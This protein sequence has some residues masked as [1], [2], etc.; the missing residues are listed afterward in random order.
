MPKSNP[1]AVAALMLAAASAAVPAVAQTAENTA[2]Q[3]IAPS[4]AQSAALAKAAQD[5][6]ATLT[7]EQRA[8]TVFAFD[9]PE[10]RSR[11]T[12]FPDGAVLQRL[13]TRWGDLDETQQSALM[14][15]LGALL[16]ERG[17]AMVQNQMDADDVVASQSSG[18]S[19]SGRPPVNFGGDFYYVSFVGEPSADAP[20]M[21]Q[22]GGHHLAIN[23]TVVGPDITLSPMLTGGE[24][25]H[26]TRNGEN[27]SIT[28]EEVDAAFALASSLTNEQ[29]AVA[30]ISDT[31]I[32][33]Q[34]GPG[35]DGKTLPPEGLPGSEMTDEQKALF[36][37]LIEARL[38]V[39]NAD[40]LAG[41][42]AT[43]TEGLDQTYLGWW[44]PIAAGEP[45]Y[46]RIT[47]P[48]VLIE[49]S[50]EDNDGDAT[51]HAHN[52]YRDPANEYGAAWIALP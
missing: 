26:F 30:V 21:L 5:F 19:D 48:R 51:N 39:L 22:F 36:T 31:R 4:D 49:F 1:L 50:P 45:A 24:P 29:R 6:L 2:Q 7:P 41:T 9:D 38:G 47:G 52:I 37:D 15:M 13:G 33:L 17:A 18:E 35:E 8:A 27:V 25:L 34:L 16:S 12:N 44:G 32:N 11:W 43:I 28:G 23:A 14:T 42:M 10:Q 46:F 3:T 40:D 20:W